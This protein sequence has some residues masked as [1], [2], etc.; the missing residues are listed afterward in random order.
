MDIIIPTWQGFYE[1]EMSLIVYKVAQYQTVRVTL[2]YLH[3]EVDQKV[4][5]EEYLGI[6][7]VESSCYF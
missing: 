1:D 3:E 6:R 4:K 7:R 2:Q 5:E